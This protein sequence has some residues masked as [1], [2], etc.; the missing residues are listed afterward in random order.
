M[1]AADP[2]SAGGPAGALRRAPPSKGKAIVDTRSRFSSK[3]QLRLF[4]FA[5]SECREVF[6]FS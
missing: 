1:N 6:R 3:P 4:F 2:G 5:S